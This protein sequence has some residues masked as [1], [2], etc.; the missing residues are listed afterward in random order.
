[1]GSKYQWTPDPALAVMV[2]VVTVIIVL[3]PAVCSVCFHL[4]LRRTEASDRDKVYFC[5]MISVFLN[6]TQSLRELILKNEFVE[7]N[8]KYPAT[9]T[10]L[11][12]Q[13]HLTVKSKRSGFMKKWHISIKKKL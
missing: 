10:H 13:K 7:T 1:M 9:H 5:Y 12:T 11:G 2:G 6:P 8:D 3:I 4:H